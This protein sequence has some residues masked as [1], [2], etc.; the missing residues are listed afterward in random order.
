MTHRYGIAKILLNLALDRPFE[1]IIPEHLAGRIAPGMKVTVPFGN[2]DGTREAFVVAL[3]ESSGRTDLKEILSVCPGKLKIPQNL[4]KL[5]DW[6]ADYYCCPREHALRNLLPSAVRS[7]KVKPKTESR[8]YAG[9]ASAIAEYTAKAKK[10]QMPRVEILKLVNV[11]GGLSADEIL[12]RTKAPKSALAAL[13]K[14][15][16]VTVQAEEVA[17][18]P[19]K[20]AEI[21][22]SMPLEP[23]DEQAAALDKI[24]SL[25]DNPAREK[26]TVLLHGITCSGKT[27]VYLQSIAHVLETGGD[28][29]VL[30]PEISLTPQTVTRFKSRFGDQVSVLHSGLS[31]GE[32]RDEWMK[33]MTGDVKIAVGAR[34]ALFAPFTNLKLIIVDEEQ[35]T[36]AINSPNPPLTTRETWR[37]RGKFENA[38]VI[39]GSATPSLESYRKALNGKYELLKMLKRSD[40]AFVLPRVNVVDMRLE[41]KDDGKIPFLSK[42]LV[43]SVY[44]RIQSGEQSIIFLNKRGYARRLT[45]EKCDFVAT[46]PDCSRADKPAPYTYHKKAGT[47]TCH[48]CGNVIP[49]LTKCPECGND[50]VKYFGAGTERIEN[51]SNSLFKGARIARMDSD[52]MTNPAKYEQTLSAFRRGDLDILIGTQMI[53]KGLDFPNVTLVGIVN[54]DMS[55]Y[56]PIF[57]RARTNLQLLGAGRRRAGRD[58]AGR[59]SHYPDMQP[60]R[61]RHHVRLR[62]RLYRILQRRNIRPRRYETAA[63]HTYYRPAVRRKRRCGNSQRGKLS[64]QLN[65]RSIQR[66]KSRIHRPESGSA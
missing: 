14:D 64:C 46:C 47:L 66:K 26:H 4:L 34:S 62:T 52:T 42:I 54:A 35:R 55:L 49:A 21:I 28:S 7:G 43:D 59:R 50:D 36:Q 53:A 65:E 2:G 3:A 30:V 45:C 27:E 23:T 20:N 31:D 41:Q 25:L 8:Y 29:I 9:E 13:V 44:Q 60:L 10:P 58:M 32:R 12:E 22:P 57:A 15:G 24:K 18:D 11:R 51:I 56:I 37:V 17:R 19:F 16:L 61:P 39:L 1:Y 38:L 40:P 5:G 63:R 48:I 6:M 33:V